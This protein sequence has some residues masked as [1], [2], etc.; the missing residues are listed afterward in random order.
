[1]KHK[2]TRQCAALM[3]STAL[4]RSFSKGKIAAGLVAGAAGAFLLATPR[5]A[6]AFMVYNGPQ[7]GNNLLINLSTTVSWTPIWRT[8]NPSKVLTSP[9][10]ANGSEGDLDFAHGLVN[11]EFSILPVLDIKDGNYGAHFSGEAYINTSYLGTNQNSQPDTINPISIAKHTDFTSATRNVEG[12]NARPLDAFVYGRQYFG[13]DDQQSF[14]LK[15]GRQTLLWGQSFLLTGNGIVAGM[16]PIDVIQAQNTPNAQTQ[17]V[18][19]P[20]GQVVGTYQPNQVLTLQG[21]YQFEWQPDFFQGVGAFFNTT[22]LLDKGGQR[23][24][25]P[26]LGNP[27]RS[28]DLR[29]GQNGQFGGSVQ[30]TLNGLDLGFYALRYDSK[31]PAIYVAPLTSNYYLVYPRDIW[32][33]GAS[34]STIVGATQWAG[35][36]SFRQH[37]NLDGGLG[38]SLPNNPGNANSDPLYPVG[39]IV[40]G[41]T[42][43]WYTSPSLPFLPGG[44]TALGEIGFNHVLAVNQNQ[45]QIAAGRSPTAVIAAA[46]V[47]PQI[48]DAIPYLN[49]S[50]PIGFNYNIYGRS[51]AFANENHGTGNVNFGITATYRVTWIASVTFTDFL[52]APNIVLNGGADRNNIELNIQHSF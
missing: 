3:S 8:N 23:L 9:E 21:Y 51:M 40:A 26:A 44:F 30:L 6:D 13:A 20:V 25:A 50:F 37:M 52:G 12:L 18:I 2:I 28:K 29:P 17:Q 22:D 35:E 48:L 49:L 32:I 4:R 31:S 10:N 19:E 1:M 24:L 27:L 38:I 5:Q 7:Y 41:Q 14:T 33:E 46:T 45:D 16:A 34:F 15:V 42:S 39:T 43:G 11:D 36:M 47:T